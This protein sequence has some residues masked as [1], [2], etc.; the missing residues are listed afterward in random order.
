MY[1]SV[2]CPLY[3]GEQYIEKLTKSLNEQK[4]V[5]IKEILYI[6]TEVEGDNS[7]EKLK[8]KN[9]RYIVISPSVFSHS[10]TR[11]KAAYNAKGDIVVFIS[12]DIEIKDDMWLYKL[13]K[14]IDKGICDAS[15]SK[16][17]CENRTIE[18]YTRM[19]NYPDKSRIVSKED[20]KKL[21]IMAYFFSDAASAIKKSTFVE[22]E[23]YDGK[24]LLT[25]EDMYIAYKLINNGFKIKYCADA[26][27]IH[28]HKYTYK[29]LFK[30]YFDQGVFLKQ[31][32]YIKDSGA[33]GSAIDLVKFVAVNSIKEKNFSAFF[34]IIPNFAI[35]FIGDK[36]GSKYEKLTKDK[37]LK[38]TANK[39]Y[40]MK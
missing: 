12:Q 34:D 7:I 22:L 32:N 14:D 3:K 40:W 10:L 4:K 33:S 29:S 21:G 25:N 38:Y 11:E 2:I 24:D 31:H 8:K 17:I 27:V 23:G 19:K 26:E 9:A 36:F 37:I 13:T 28:S 35:R 18:R 16:Q 39:N 1:L 5:Q 20:V 6:V 15:F 30:R